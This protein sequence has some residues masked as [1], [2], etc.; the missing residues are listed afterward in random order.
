MLY[1]FKNFV[2]ILDEW[3]ALF[4]SKLFI[5]FS[6]LVRGTALKENLKLHF[7]AIVLMFGCSRFLDIAVKNSSPFSGV[8]Q[9]KLLVN[10]LV[11]FD[12]L[13]YLFLYLLLIFLPL[14]D[15]LLK[16]LENL[17]SNLQEIYKHLDL[18]VIIKST[19]E[20]GVVLPNKLLKLCV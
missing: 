1:F 11:F 3:V 2:D 17:V 4:M 15:L 18:P 20:D 9:S 16:K 8:W 5:S 6:I 7:S 10:F 14:T 12:K 19:R 13:T